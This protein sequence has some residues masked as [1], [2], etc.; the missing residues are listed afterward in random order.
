MTPVARETETLRTVCNRCRGPA[1][2]IINGRFCISCYN[3][4]CEALKGKNARGGRPALSDQLRVVGVAVS[5]GDDV[6]VE[7]QPFLTGAVE[8]LIDQAR[9]A[10]AV[11]CFGWAICGPGDAVDLAA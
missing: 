4:H 8:L 11:T 1:A 2:R 10:K 9:K 7:I 5:A 6:R 3:R